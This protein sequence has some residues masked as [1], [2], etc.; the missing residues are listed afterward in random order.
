M[1]SPVNL[2]QTEQEL[3][4]ASMLTKSLGIGPPSA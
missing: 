3:M 4:L 2:K 1:S